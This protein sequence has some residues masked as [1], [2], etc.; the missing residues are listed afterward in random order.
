M[1]AH[2]KLADLILDAIIGYSLSG[3]PR[4]VSASL[5]RAVNDHD[6]PVLSLDVP[7]GVD[8]ATGSVYDPSIKADATLTLALPKEGLKG[9]AARERVGELYIGDISIPPELYARPP[10]NL[11]VGPIFADDSIVR[12]W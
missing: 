7:S 6:A 3:A 8:T 5:I 4:G 11:D 1:P 12:L 9:D 2:V 10:L